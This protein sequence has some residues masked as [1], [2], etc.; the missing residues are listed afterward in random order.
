MILSEGVWI[1]L[2]LCLGQN[3]LKFPDK[4][5][6]VVFARNI[7][8]TRVSFGL[9]GF[10]RVRFQGQHKDIFDG[11][12]MDNGEIR[13]ALLCVDDTDGFQVADTAFFKFSKEHRFCRGGELHLREFCRFHLIIMNGARSFSRYVHEN[14]FIFRTRNVKLPNAS[15]RDFSIFACIFFDVDEINYRDIVSCVC[16]IL[17]W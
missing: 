6:G 14:Q 5:S 1:V 2:L 10:D 7:E 9:D 12:S 3:I 15:S 13:T 16:V 4:Y 17:P 11:R 8:T